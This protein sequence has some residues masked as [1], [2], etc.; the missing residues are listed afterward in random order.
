MRLRI[1][2]ED[3]LE[4]MMAWRS[5]PLV[6]DGFYQQKKPLEWNEHVAWFKSRNQ[7]W[8]TFIIEHDGRDVGVVTIGQLDHWSPEIGYYVGEV[9]LWGQ[10]VGRDAVREA[11]EYLKSQGK[12][13]CH[14]TVLTRNQRSLRLL[15]S[16]GFEEYGKAREG[17]VWLQKKLS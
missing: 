6:F 9:S 10:G 4:L 3:D 15:T 11:L 17:E 1:A 14:T 12:D 5:N 16:L 13:Y 7:D 8:R 2:T